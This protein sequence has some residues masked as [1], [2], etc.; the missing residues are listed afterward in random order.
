MSLLQM[1]KRR[2]V[3]E[4]VQDSVVMADGVTIQETN[5]PS[6][7]L[8]LIKT[9]YRDGEEIDEENMIEITYQGIYDKGLTD[10]EKQNIAVIVANLAVSY[11][12]KKR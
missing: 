3:L 9:K 5:V 6:S 7:Q 8:G 11:I 2:T 12:N 4:G 1:P 10:Q